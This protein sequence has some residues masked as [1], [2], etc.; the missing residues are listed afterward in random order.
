M[1]GSSFSPDVK[2]FIKLLAKYNVRYV[3]VGGE[4]VI[5]YGFVRLTGDIDFFY[6]SSGENANRLFSALLEFWQGTIPG[7]KKVDDLVGEDVIIQFGIIPN[8]IDLITSIDGVEFKEVWEDRLEEK[9][10]I[11]NKEYPIYFIGLDQLIKN[12]ESAK[13]D[14]DLMDV[15]YLYALKKKAPPSPNSKGDS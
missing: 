5:Y 10:L 9:I 1:K 3:I 7:I 14:K 12:K 4:A 13:R 11:G 6:E 2:D 8:R 15:K